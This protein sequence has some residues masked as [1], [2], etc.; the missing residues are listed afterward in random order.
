M[1]KT[2]M[3]L[4]MYMSHVVRLIYVSKI[5]SENTDIWDIHTK[6]ELQ[7][8]V[9]LQTLVFEP[10]SDRAIMYLI[11]FKCFQKIWF[12]SGKC[13][14]FS[15][16]LKKKKKEKL[17]NCTKNTFWKYP[18]FQKIKKKNCFLFLKKIHNFFD[19]SQILSDTGAKYSVTQILYTEY[20]V[21]CI[22]CGLIEF[23]VL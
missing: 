10:E 6:P 7:I 13:L 16:S 17:K 21:L 23:I 20:P 8:F 4:R 22:F 18:T 14:L 12:Y 9:M 5:F 19:Q 1:T 2:L 11:R 15:S 3:I